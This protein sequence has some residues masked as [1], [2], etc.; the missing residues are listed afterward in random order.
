MNNSDEQ[1]I[2]YYECFC[3]LIEFF[4][5]LKLIYL[6]TFFHTKLLK[7]RFCHIPLNMY[8]IFEVF[9][10][11]EISTTGPCSSVG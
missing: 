5:P 7:F 10:Y 3:Y 1:E 2:F 11:M 9:V 4:P 8:I 6:I